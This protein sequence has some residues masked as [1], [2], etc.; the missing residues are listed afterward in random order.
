MQIARA[1]CAEL[2]VGR[3]HL[4]VIK[5]AAPETAGA[6]ALDR[7]VVLTHRA[8]EMP[9]RRNIHERAVRR[10]RVPTPANNPAIHPPNRAVVPLP[11]A[12]IAV[13]PLRNLKQLR[14]PTAPAVDAAGDVQGAGVVAASVQRDVAICGSG[15]GGLCEGQGGKQ[16]SGDRKPDQEGFMP[17]PPDRASA[18]NAR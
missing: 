18:A 4:S 10:V 14:R 17:P 11:R 16:Q 1:D 12:D 8:G 6:P 7:T 15:R 3:V 9:A 5:D 2:A 13:A